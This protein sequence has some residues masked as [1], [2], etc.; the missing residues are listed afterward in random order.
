MMMGYGYGGV[1]G[2]LGM[3][4][5]V[6]I[7]L[8]FAALVILSVIW[9]FKTVF[10]SAQAIQPGIDAVQIVKQRYAKGEISEEEYHR[11]LNQLQ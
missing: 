6:V 3:G 8:A 9:L 10:R 1:L 4:L 11:L 7:H 2:W 5:G